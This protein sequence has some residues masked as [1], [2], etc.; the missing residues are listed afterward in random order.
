LPWSTLDVEVVGTL[1]R[2]GRNSRF[3]RV[4]I[5]ARLGI[6]AEADRELFEHALQRAEEGSLIS[7]SL[8]AERHLQ[9]SIEAVAAAA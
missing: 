9:V 5:H 1:E 3:T 8:S 2:E 7:N 6:A 4:D